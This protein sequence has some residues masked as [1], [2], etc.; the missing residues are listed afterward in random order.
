MH[1]YVSVN[2]EEMD[3]QR[4]LLYKNIVV[5][6]FCIDIQLPDHK[7]FQKHTDLDIDN[8]YKLDGFYSQYLKR[9]LDDIQHSVLR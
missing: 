6:G 7:Y 3:L 9:I 4:N 5:Y 2:I 8:Q 1:Y